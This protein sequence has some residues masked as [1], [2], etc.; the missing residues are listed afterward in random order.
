MSVDY[1]ILLEKYNLLCEENDNLKEEIMHLR[2]ILTP[3]VGQV[4]NVSEAPKGNGINKRS[5]PEDK[6][7]L[8]RSL[9]KGRED[10]FARR[11][12]SK[13]TDKSGYQPVCENE[14][15]EKMCDKKMYKCSSCPN[16]KLVAL[17]DK[18]IYKHLSGKDLYGRDVIGIYPML[19][20]ETCCFLCADFDEENYRRDVIAFKSTCTELNVPAYIERSRSGNGAH[21][22]I[23]FSE[24]VS[25]R[26][27]RR[28]GSGILTRA[29]ERANISFKSYDRLF[30][31]QDTMPK[32]GFGNLIALPLQG[33]ARK[34]SNSLFVDE[35]FIPYPDQWAFLSEVKRLSCENA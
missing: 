24:H 18:D 13:T 6:I 16:R 25:V 33:M 20:D 31:N 4:S 7:A 8:F 32:G 10:V 30:P 22:W 19:Q 21:V 9:F 26:T 17:T 29:M 14:W 2:S 3:S 15:D 5:S 11:W 34:N 35:H 28:L 27:A 12:Y 1:Q 23:F